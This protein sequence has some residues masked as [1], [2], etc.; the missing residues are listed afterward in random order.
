M[1]KIHLIVKYMITGSILV[2]CL[3]IYFSGMKPEVTYSREQDKHVLFISSY[4]ESFLSVPDQIKGLS[5]V[6]KPLNIQLDVEYMDT[7]RFDTKEGIKLFYNLLKYKMENLEPYDAVIV[8]DDNALQFAMD[9]Q[10]DLFK[11][12]PVV[13]LGVN[14]YDRA[15]LAAA[16]PYII[17]WITL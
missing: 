16:N 7:K 15:K 6:F 2:V 12:L 8:G 4:T 11:G 1:K 14:D 13:F 10:D 17:F 3:L 5:D 9:Y